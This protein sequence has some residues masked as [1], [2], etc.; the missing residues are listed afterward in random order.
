MVERI[1]LRYG[2]NEGLK[3]VF[4]KE[5]TIEKLAPL[6]LPF[7]LDYFKDVK[8]GDLPWHQTLLD[9]EGYDI[10][11]LYMKWNKSAIR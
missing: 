7:T 2:Y 8:K 10:L 3:L 4:G 6:S 1:L 11:T 5:E 9:G